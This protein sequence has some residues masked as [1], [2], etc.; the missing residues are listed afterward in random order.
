MASAAILSGS[1][2]LE[3]EKNQGHYR[4]GDQA[5]QRG[6]NDDALDF[7]FNRFRTEGL[8]P[9]IFPDREIGIYEFLTLFRNPATNTLGA[10][11]ENQETLKW[12]LCGMLWVVD[13]AKMDSFKRIGVGHGFFRG[14]TDP[15][16]LVRFAHLGLEWVFSELGVDMVYGITPQSN[17]AATLF[18]RKVGFSV[19][20]PIPGM[21][22]WMGSMAPGVVSSMTR[23]GWENSVN[24][25]R[26]MG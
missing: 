11:Q 26:I 2:Q 24:P 8:L 7:A 12:D 3:L 6:L 4:C 20:D 5:V 1:G 25:W 16:F 9:W 19:S 23:L 15:A 14:F 18:S 10:F 17:R 22:S 21:A 13:N